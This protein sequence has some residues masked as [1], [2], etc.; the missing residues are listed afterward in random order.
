MEY[1]GGPRWRQECETGGGV[2]G[3]TVPE[4]TGHEVRWR[5]GWPS[6]GEMLHRKGHTLKWLRLR[7][8]LL[9]L[10]PHPGS[11]L[12]GATRGHKGP[13]STQPHGIMSIW[14]FFF[15]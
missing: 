13:S 4:E 3:G 6:P 12:R 9:W 1:W 2:G 11:E 14:L 7:R 8:G 5:A 10:Q 15:L